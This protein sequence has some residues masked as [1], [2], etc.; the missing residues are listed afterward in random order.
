MIISTTFG[1]A[2]PQQHC[3]GLIPAP[4]RSCIHLL[5]IGLIFVLTLYSLMYI[6]ELEQLVLHW[7]IVS[8]W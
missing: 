1:S 4:Q 2:Y 6:V 3:L 7:H 8:V 5:E